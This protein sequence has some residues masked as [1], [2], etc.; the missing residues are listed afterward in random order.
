[1]FNK[2]DIVVAIK[3]DSQGWLL[4]SGL[5]VG[6]IVKAT[7]QNDYYLESRRKF[8]DCIYDYYISES[9]FRLATKE[10]IEAYNQGIRNIK[11][12]KKSDKITSREQLI[13][14]EIYVF[15][16]KHLN[17]IGNKDDNLYISNYICIHNS[18]YSNISTLNNDFSN[19]RLATPEEKR[20]LE[21]CIKANKF[22]SKEEALKQ[23]EVKSEVIPEYVEALE[24]SGICYKKGK[25]YKVKSIQGSSILTEL[26]EKGSTTNGWH[27]DNFKPSTKE[28]YDAQFSKKVEEKPK[29]EVGKWYKFNN[30]SFKNP[31]TYAKFLKID[32]DKYFWFSE[33]IGDEN[34]RFYNG[35]WYV[36]KVSNILTDLS[37][38]QQYLPEGHPDKFEKKESKCEFKVGDFVGC[39]GFSG[40]NFYEIAKIEGDRFWIYFIPKKFQDS[41]NY[42][43]SD[44]P[45]LKKKPFEYSGFTGFSAT[46][47]FPTK[48]ELSKEE[49]LE[50]AKRRYPIGTEY[51]AIGGSKFISEGTVRLIKKGDKGCSGDINISV[52]K[53]GNYKGLVYQDGKWADIISK[54]EEIFQVDYEVAKPWVRTYYSEKKSI[55]E[56]TDYSKSKFNQKLEVKVNK[57]SKV[58]SK[59]VLN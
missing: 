29:F 10:E 30:T 48:K 33:Y 3:K 44:H 9:S 59:L 43:F 22:I 58:K 34:H 5:I 26:D 18:Y 49:L 13:N 50:E 7:E 35:N 4:K 28:A 11:D 57:K 6:S 8:S 12:I 56:P 25:I 52:C 16:D 37:E 36:D 27:K 24:S 40:K 31:K 14:G 15:N 17:K 46:L 20:W 47:P 2:D 51:E 45:N 21:A 53:I 41:H 54:P 1:M 42:K 39:E 38:I 19:V 23:V 55:L 32:D